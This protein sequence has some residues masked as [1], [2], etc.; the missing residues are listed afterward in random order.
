M[1]TTN[2]KRGLYAK[3]SV[4]RLN[5]IRSDTIDLY[6]AF[7][8]TEDGSVLQVKFPYDETLP[9]TETRQIKSNI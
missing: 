3:V 4:D 2:M 5:L 1:K 8:D 7:A 6:D 9:L